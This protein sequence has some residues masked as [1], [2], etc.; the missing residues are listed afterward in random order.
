[1]SEHSQ[2]PNEETSYDMSF[3]LQPEKPKVFVSDTGVLCCGVPVAI[4]HGLTKT[5][6]GIVLMALD[7][8]S[9]VGWLIEHENG[10][11]MF[12]NETI[13]KHFECL[14]DL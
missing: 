10:V 13:E 2:K 11:T 3:D 5:T 6:V 4:A 9:L 14:G 12:N 8:E 1:M 7:A